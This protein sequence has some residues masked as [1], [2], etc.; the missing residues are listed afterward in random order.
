MFQE[1]RKCSHCNKVF[2]VNG[3]RFCC[4]KTLSCYYCSKRFIVVKEGD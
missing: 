2:V 1:E 4:A 3:F